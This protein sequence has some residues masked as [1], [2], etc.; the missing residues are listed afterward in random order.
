MSTRA[1]TLAALLLA[2]I[3]LAEAAGNNHALI[4]EAFPAGQQDY[5]S[6]PDTALYK[7][8][9]NDPYLLFELLDT[10]GYGHRFDLSVIPASRI[11]L[12]KGDT[13]PNSHCAGHTQHRNVTAGLRDEQG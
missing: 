9:W 4:V 6:P 2:A 3:G 7:A 12:S 1:S 5:S 8:F 10:T 11:H 13:I